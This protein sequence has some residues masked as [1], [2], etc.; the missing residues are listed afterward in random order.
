MVADDIAHGAG[1]ESHH[2]ASEVW[3]A[4]YVRTV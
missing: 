2:D 4:H 3:A 1:V